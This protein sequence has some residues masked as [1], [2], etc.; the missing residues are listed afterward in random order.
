[1]NSTQR[2]IED[3]STRQFGERPPDAVY[4]SDESN[5]A[6]ADWY[7]R[8]GQPGFVVVQ[9]IGLCD[10]RAAMVRQLQFVERLNRASGGVLSYLGFHSGVPRR[11]TPRNPWEESLQYPSAETFVARRDELSARLPREHRLPQFRVVGDRLFTDDEYAA[12]RREGVFPLT[13]G[14]H[15]SHDLIAHAIVH[16]LLSPQSDEAHQRSIIIDHECSLEDLE[17]T[18][19][20]E[21][22]E[23][24][25]KDL[26]RR[27]DTGLSLI[28][29]AADWGNPPPEHDREA[30][31][32]SSLMDV[33]MDAA[34][35]LAGADRRHIAYL[36]NLGL[37]SLAAAS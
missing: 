12:F 35:R 16:V 28:G 22:Y 29:I 6:I 31:E 3:L 5:G 2:M 37:G 17:D 33:D 4:E 11:E 9:G 1:M 23:T 19:D 25:M 18:G 30:Q 34:A 7:P 27:S 10:V 24:A 14:E 21:A 32:Y 15:S 36:A 26:M 13:T 8:D 20:R